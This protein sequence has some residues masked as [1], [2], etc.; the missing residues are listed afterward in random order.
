MRDLC[1]PDDQL[2][3]EP[4]QVAAAQLAKEQALPMHL[5]E[6]KTG[7][8]QVRSNA[9]MKKSQK[10]A[11]AVLEAQRREAKLIRDATLFEAAFAKTQRGEQFNPSD[12]VCELPVVLPFSFLSESG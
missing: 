2:Q 8:L 1:S 12:K 7:S 3:Q 10:R 4:F 9:L 11:A 6:R 5:V